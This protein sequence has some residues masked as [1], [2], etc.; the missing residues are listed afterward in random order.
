M[1]APQFVIRSALMDDIEAIC[2]LGKRGH[3]KSEFAALAYDEG[4]VKLLIANCIVRKT[5]CAYIA[6]SDGKIVG[7]ILGQEDKHPFVKMQFATDIALYSE[8]PGAG[9][10]LLERFKVWALEERKVDRL[11]MAVSSGE[12][13]IKSTA[14]MYTRLGFK[15]IGCF[16]TMDRS[17]V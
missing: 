15:H 3:D 13:S 8:S 1:T 14:A 9:R 5:L 16:F 10:K 2:E 4:S 7:V 6:E 11:M 17:V 12:K